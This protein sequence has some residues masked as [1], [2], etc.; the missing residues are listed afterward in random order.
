MEIKGRSVSRYARTSSTNILKLKGLGSCIILLSV[1]LVVVWAFNATSLAGIQKQFLHWN[2]FSHILMIVFGVGAI[3]IHKADF[4]SYGFTIK[5]WRFDL[6]VATICV[7]MV[8]GFI[9]P[10]ILPSIAA[11]EPVSEIIKIATILL[12]LVLVATK[13]NKGVEGNPVLPVSSYIFAT[14]F[15]VLGTDALA[16]LGLISSTIVFQFFFVGFGEEILFRGYM[17]TRLNE[18]FGMPW[19]FKDVRFGPGLLISSALFGVLHLL[20]PFNPFMGSY[21]L[22]VWSAIGSGF[23]GLL[24]G[25]VR[26]K[27]GTVLSA[28]LAHGLV[29]LGQVVPLLL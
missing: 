6:S 24:F 25:F 17:Q 9:P 2:Y 7:I 4:H 18:D 1:L 10:F 15:I 5:N 27:T 8:A 19:R 3:A 28:S 20:N 11:N 12:P 16:D 14:P 29:D 22:A 23:A 21:D 13:K 26:E